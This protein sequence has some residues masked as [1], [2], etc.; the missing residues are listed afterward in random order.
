MMKRI[1]L[2]LMALVPLQMVGDSNAARSIYVPR[3]LSYNPVYE[4]ALTYHQKNMKEDWCYLVSVKPVYAQTLGSKLD[5]YFSINQQSCMAV[6]EN[7]SGN[8]DSLWLQN[9]SSNPSYYSSILS[10]SPV[11]RTGGAVMFFQTQLPW[12]LAL[13]IDTAL[14]YTN[15]T[16]N[17]VE[18]N[19]TNP[20]TS[21]FKS[22]QQAL[23]SSDYCF[24][25]ICGNRG[26]TGLDDI[27]VKLIKDIRD[28]ECYH[29]DVYGLL[30]IP[31]NK[32]SKAHYLFEPL[33]GSKHVQLG[34]GTTGYANLVDNDCGTL[35][36]QGEVKY[37]YA[38]GA[39]ER[40][41]FDLCKNGQWSR[42]MLVVNQD[43]LYTAVPAVNALTFET[44]V[45]P[46]S[47]LDVYAG[48]HFEYEHVQIELGYDF[49]YRSAEHVCPNVCKNIAQLG[50]ADLVGIAQLNPRTASTANISQSVA[51]GSNQMK[52]DAS[53]VP[54]SASDINYAS[55]A[56]PRVMSNTIY[57][58]LA[59]DYEWCGHT[60]QVGLNASY[61][62]GTNANKADV[63]AGW[64]NFDWYL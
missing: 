8:I 56:N 6:R 61:E 47:S 5:K 29:W 32:G 50:I 10:F 44:K 64:I 18:K 31:T 36:L 4:N 22:V 14:V 49:W 33:V 53:F 15:N 24:G 30:G 62:R 60:V 1:S 38:F 37:R 34:L 11:S 59:G 23:A 51:A 3:Q 9:I 20:G 27:Q 26:T 17:I 46:R 28:S 39:H 41:S 42:Y 13:S 57:L 25:R 19:I 21:R 2:G 52:S 55:G 58:S 54:L 43:D 7:G 12:S 35:S 16:M 48:L 45:T 40:R 63:V